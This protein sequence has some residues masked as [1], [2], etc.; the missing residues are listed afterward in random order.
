MYS[1][2]YRILL[3]TIAS[4][5]WCVSKYATFWL[6]LIRL[7]WK[8]HISP[9][10]NVRVAAMRRVPSPSSSPNPC[11]KYHV[12]SPPPPPQLEIRGHK[13][14][15][16]WPREFRPL[17]P[18]HPSGVP[19]SFRQH[20]LTPQAGAV[21]L[22]IMGRLAPPR[23]S[24]PPHWNAFNPRTLCSEVSA[25]VLVNILIVQRWM[26]VPCRRLLGLPSS[27]SWGTLGDEN[28]GYNEMSK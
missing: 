5:V 18:P 14:G 16:T 26:L 25:G 6:P 15:E 1:G 4:C 11:I 27:D 12:T 22:C 3:W 24:Q 9:T 8:E 2:F 28:W 10:S 19:V 20:S 13:V 17:S 7:T 23:S 21:V